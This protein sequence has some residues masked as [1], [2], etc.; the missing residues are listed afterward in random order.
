[1][2]GGARGGAWEIIAVDQTRYAGSR[3]NLDGVKHSESNNGGGP[4]K[5]WP[6]L[7][8]PAL[9]LLPALLICTT[10]PFP[11]A[12]LPPSSTLLLHLYSPPSPPLPLTCTL[13]GT[14]S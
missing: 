3:S 5:G 2:Q 6:S 13:P 10:F 1:M 12:P 9:L 7:R 8:S 4:N 11:T 14:P